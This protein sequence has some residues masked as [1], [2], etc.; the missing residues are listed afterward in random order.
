MRVDGLDHVHIEVRDR[1]IAAAWYNRVLGLVP[2]PKLADW[3]EDPKGP[4]ILATMSGQAALSLFMRECA[5]PSRDA[6]IA[7]RVSGKAFLEFANRLTE[8]RLSHVTGAPLT[9][10]HLVDHKL[11]WSIYFKDLDEN[12][13]ELT[14]YDVD[15]VRASI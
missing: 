8:L 15:V 14:T 13:L 10:D 3:A 9:R 6:T 4:L 5:P 11:S 1:H 2:H 12:R 7:F